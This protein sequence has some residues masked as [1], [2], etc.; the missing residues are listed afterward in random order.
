MNF[1]QAKN[2]GY[3]EYA[4]MRG[5][6]VPREMLT[7]CEK[8]GKL[9]IFPRV[10]YRIYSVMLALSCLEC[11]MMVFAGKRAE[12][13]CRYIQKNKREDFLNDTQTLT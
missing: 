11:Q 13:G 10:W 4:G 5:E 2:G 3:T 7:N 8:Y 1:P 6:S 12:S 9:L